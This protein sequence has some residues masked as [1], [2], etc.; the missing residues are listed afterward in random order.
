M[1]NDEQAY[2]FGVLAFSKRKKESQKI[3]GKGF[4][5]PTDC[6]PICRRPQNGSTIAPQIKHSTAG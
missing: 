3:T 4:P 2:V 5:F 1:I 6:P